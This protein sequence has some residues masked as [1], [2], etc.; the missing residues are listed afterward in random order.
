MR[1][2]IDGK[3]VSE[4]QA[5]KQQEINSRILSIKDPDE[6]MEALKNAKFII[7]LN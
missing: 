5:K 7:I 6:F 2:F 4:E 1:Y 3:E